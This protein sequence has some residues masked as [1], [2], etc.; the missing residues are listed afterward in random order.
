MIVL[1]LV[2]LEIHTDVEGVVERLVE[3]TLILAAEAVGMPPM[4]APRAQQWQPYLNLIH[5]LNRKHGT[6]APGT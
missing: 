2:V 5:E 3:H 1:E 4:P 6:G